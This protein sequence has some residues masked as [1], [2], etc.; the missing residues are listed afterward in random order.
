[1][2]H[3]FVSPLYRPG[4]NGPKSTAHEY[5]SF[6]CLLCPS[7]VYPQVQISTVALPEQ[8]T[9]NIGSLSLGSLAGNFSTRQDVCLFTR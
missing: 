3:P 9:T 2:T 7:Y 6:P 1:M 5:L 8:G 4:L